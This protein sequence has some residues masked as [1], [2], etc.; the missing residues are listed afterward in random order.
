M[1]NPV[2]RQ[3]ATSDNLPL[4]SKGRNCHKL[5]NKQDVWL[6]FSAHIPIWKEN[7][8]LTRRERVYVRNFD[9]LGK[10]DFLKSLK[11]ENLLKQSV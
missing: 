10:N 8:P 3:L 7:H 11:V 1:I 2:Q 9:F 6:L 4:N 5:R